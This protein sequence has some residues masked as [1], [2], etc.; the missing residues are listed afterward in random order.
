VKIDI[1]EV[2]AMEISAEHVEANLKTIAA[3]RARV[4]AATTF[5]DGM[6]LAVQ[7]VCP[8][9]KKRDVYDPGYAGGGYDYTYCVTCG[10]RF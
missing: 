3:A 5:L 6:I 1:S 10:K 7:A 8:H 9:E 4:K 2:T